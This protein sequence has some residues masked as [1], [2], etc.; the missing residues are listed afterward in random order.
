MTEQLARDFDSTPP[1]IGLHIFAEVDDA[2]VEVN[3]RPTQI[4]NRFLASPG[5]DRKQDE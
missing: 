4:Q 5:V 3:L 2:M 1:L